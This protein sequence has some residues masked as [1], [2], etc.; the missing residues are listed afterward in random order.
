MA[1]SLNQTTGRRVAVVAALRTPFAR[2]NTVYRDLSAVDL[3]RMVV[4]E[5]IERSGIPPAR[6]GQ[7]V[8]G[9]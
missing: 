4:A 3:G 1:L 5:L 2:R 9:R 8:Y 7:L 6:V